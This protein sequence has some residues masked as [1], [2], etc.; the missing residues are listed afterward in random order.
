[1]MHITIFPTWRCQLCCPYCWVPHVQINRHVQERTW[2]DW[3]MALTDALRPG[4]T[5]DLAGGEPLL[6]VGLVDLLDALG[7]RGLNWAISTNALNTRAIERLVDRRP[8]RCAL[9]N[10]SDHVGNAQASANIALLRRHFPVRAHRVA[11]VGAGTHESDAGQIVYQAWAEGV[12]LDGIKRSCDAGRRHWVADPAGD[13]W[14][15]AVEMQLGLPSLGNLFDRTVRPVE[16][17]ICEHGCTTA[18]SLDGPAWGIMM[19]EVMLCTS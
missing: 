15:C 3:A 16:S 8:P 2:Q 12:A 13:L 6:F 10:I 4:S 17:L 7:R 11:H 1:M 9:I 5:V 14:R 19:Q 18:Y